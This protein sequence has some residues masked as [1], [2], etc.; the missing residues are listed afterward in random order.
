MGSI[1]A[2]SILPTNNGNNLI[3]RTGVEDVERVRIS[4]SGDITVNGSFSTSVTGNINVVGNVGVTGGASFSGKITTASTTGSDSSTTLATKGYVDT[5]VGRGLVVLS[6]LTRVVNIT[7]LSSTHTSRQTI[8]L[9]PTVPSTA[10]Y[11]MLYLKHDTS[12]NTP[13]SIYMG[14]STTVNSGHEVLYAT[15]TGSE[16][17]TDNIMTFLPILHISDTSR[18]IYWNLSTTPGNSADELVVDIAGYVV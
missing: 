14:P 12:G 8:Q 16:S 4:P 9:H 13:Y 17:I 15:S 18:T 5:S 6:S 3:L 10:K 11:V 7:S 1:K 2:D